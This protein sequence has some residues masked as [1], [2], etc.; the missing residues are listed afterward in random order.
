MVRNS[1]SNNNTKATSYSNLSDNNSSASPSPAIKAIQLRKNFFDTNKNEIQITEASVNENKDDNSNNKNS[2]LKRNIADIIEEETVTNE[3][4][5]VT[6]PSKTR[7]KFIHKSSLFIINESTITPNNINNN[8]NN[9]TMNN[10]HLFPS[11]R[12]QYSDECGKL[13]TTLTTTMH[14][15]TNINTTLTKIVPFTNNTKAQDTAKASTNKVES[16]KKEQQVQSKSST[17]NNNKD[18]NNDNEDDD[19]DYDDM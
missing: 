13:T 1:N 2:N 17:N 4:V 19:E 10:T 15:S 6:S 3:D 12:S 18:S 8:T 9:I 14:P 16:N 11:Q 5:S 7:A